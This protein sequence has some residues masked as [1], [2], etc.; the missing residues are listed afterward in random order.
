MHGPRLAEA[1]LVLPRMDVD[2]HLGRVHREEQHRDRFAIRGKP[3]LQRK[4][5]GMPERPVADPAPVE[6]EVPPGRA[7][8]SDP[9]PKVHSLRG[10]LDGRGRR[11]EPAAHDLVHAFPPAPRLEDVATRMAQPGR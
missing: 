4:A 5:H 6:K 2:V 10:R 11:R 1:H 3:P 7:A 8:G 9:A